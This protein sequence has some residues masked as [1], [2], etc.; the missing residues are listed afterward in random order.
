LVLVLLATAA[1]AMASAI[2]DPDPVGPNQFFAA[3]VN[4]QSATAQ[5]AVGCDGS[6]G[7][8]LPGQT[9]EVL[10][11]SGV[12]SPTDG[13]TGTAAKAVDV[14][15]D[16]AATVPLQ[17]RFYHMVV[18]IPTSTVVPCGGQGTVAFVPD[19]TSPAARPGTVKVTFVGRS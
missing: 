14:G 4:G 16:S 13:F 18:E 10:P 2:I 1:P 17:L 7:H 8:P 19:P 6:T 5:I 3:L 11:V 12:P 9:V 15:L